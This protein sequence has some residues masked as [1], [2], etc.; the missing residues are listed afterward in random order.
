MGR[1]L[2]TTLKPDSRAALRGTGKLAKVKMYQGESVPELSTRVGRDVMRVH[3]DVAVLA[4]LGTLE[5]TEQGGAVCPFYAMHIDR[6]SKTGQ[7]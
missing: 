4:D 1:T 5:R 6:Y 3:E 2:T 7:G